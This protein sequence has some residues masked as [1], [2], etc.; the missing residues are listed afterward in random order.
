VGAYTRSAFIFPKGKGFYWFK[1][2]IDCNSSKVKNMYF[3][4]K[5]NI[6]HLWGQFTHIENITDRTPDAFHNGLFENIELYS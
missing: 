5:D 1:G 6:F 2:S 4:A 3:E